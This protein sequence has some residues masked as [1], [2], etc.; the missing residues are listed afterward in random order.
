MA[1]ENIYIYYCTQLVS[2]TDVSQDVF[3]HDARPGDLFRWSEAAG[4]RRRP[5]VRVVP[6]V[7]LGDGGARRRGSF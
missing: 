6:K 7:R 1:T 4:A 5:R 3:E 2:T